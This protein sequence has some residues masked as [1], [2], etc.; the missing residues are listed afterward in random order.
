MAD[1]RPSGLV[2]ALLGVPDRLLRGWAAGRSVF[3][4]AAST[5]RGP[6]GGPF[7]YIRAV[8]GDMRDIAFESQADPSIR[9]NPRFL[10]ASQRSI[11]PGIGSLFPGTVRGIA[12]SCN[13]NQSEVDATPKAAILSEL[14]CVET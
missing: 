13:R 12:D 10:Q 5:A 6:N 2:C 4:K 8:E 9:T 14:G 1:G 11:T 3:G 7:Q